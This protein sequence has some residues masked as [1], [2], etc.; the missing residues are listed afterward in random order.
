MTKKKKKKVRYGLEPWVNHKKVRDFIDF[1]YLNKLSDDELDYL[2]KFSTEYYSAN[3][4]N[5]E[6][7]LHQ[8]VIK[9]R[10]SYNANNARNRDVYNQ[11]IPVS[12]EDYIQLENEEED[13]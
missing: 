13:K 6:S 9:R 8:T 7:D 5:D 10:K 2:N 3:F 12:L 1:D 11:M 4:N